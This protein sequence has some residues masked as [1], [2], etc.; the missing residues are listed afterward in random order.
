MG[1][2]ALASTRQRR[3]VLAG[4]QRESGGAR[5]AHPGC[6]RLVHRGLQ[7]P[8][9]VGQLQRG[10]S[11]ARLGCLGRTHSGRR[12]EREV[13]AAGVDQARRADRSARRPGFAATRRAAFGGDR[14]RDGRPCVSRVAEEGQ[15]RDQMAAQP[16][17]VPKPDTPRASPRPPSSIDRTSST[18]ACCRR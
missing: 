13:A 4:G 17:A 1:H 15:I 14:T 16:E 8:Q 2:P 3:G 18:T 10:T 6:G 11:R 9:L 7:R 5:E 12:A